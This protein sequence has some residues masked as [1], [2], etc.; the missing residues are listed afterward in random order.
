MDVLKNCYQI[1]RNLFNGVVAEFVRSF[2]PGKGH[3]NPQFGVTVNA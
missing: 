2:M 1:Q 3:L